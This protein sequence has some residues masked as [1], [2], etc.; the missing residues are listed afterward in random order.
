MYAHPV[1]CRPSKNVPVILVPERFSPKIKWRSLSVNKHRP[2]LEL[3]FRS[4]KLIAEEEEAI[5]VVCWPLR[6]IL[7]TVAVSV[8]I[9]VFRA[10]PVDWVTNTVSQVLAFRASL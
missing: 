1:R 2:R 9:M 5:R 4:F 8:L 7:V 6:I 10:H 3:S